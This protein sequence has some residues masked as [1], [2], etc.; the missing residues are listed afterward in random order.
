MAA[1]HSTGTARGEVCSSPEHVSQ[2]RI[3]GKS[4][5][6]IVGSK[7]GGSRSATESLEDELQANLQVAGPASAG[8]DA[9]VAVP[10]LCIREIE[11]GCV[12]D[13]KRL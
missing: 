4:P 12:G 9:K 10:N 8:N 6:S 1:A 5:P 13:V 7:A 3:E 11:L 2:Q